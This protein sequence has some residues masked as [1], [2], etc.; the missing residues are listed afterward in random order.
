MDARAIGIMGIDA[1]LAAIIISGRFSIPL[2]IATT[3]TLLVSAGLAGMLVFLEND[4]RIGPLVARLLALRGLYDEHALEE[5][6]L[7][8]LAADVR[9]NERMLARG[10]RRLAL[11][12]VLLVLASLLV[13]IGSLY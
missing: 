6:I 13:L 2:R 3:A 1:A 8:G 11:A 7:E 10:G 9:A 5:T 4:E 12:F